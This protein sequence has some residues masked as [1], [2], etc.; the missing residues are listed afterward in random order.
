MSQKTI[1]VVLLICLFIPGASTV[2]STHAD[3]SSDSWV[4]MAPMNEARSG[5]GVAAV[6]GKI[7]A[8]GGS[9]ANGSV[10]SSPPQAIITNER[11]VDGFVGTNEEYDLTTDTWAYKESMPTARIG[12][13]TAVYQNKIYCIGGRTSSGY[14]NANEVYDPKTNMWEIKAPMPIPKAWIT[15]SI[16]GNKIYIVGGGVYDPV[17]NSWSLNE[18]IALSKS[19]SDSWS[20]NESIA[21]SKSVSDSWAL[22][23][24]IAPYDI[25]ASA[26]LDKKIYIVGGF[27]QDRWHN[28]NLIYN[29]ETDS[30]SSGSYPP[31]SVAT[32]VAVAFHE[33]IFVLGYSQSFNFIHIYDPYSDNW[34]LGSSP[35]IS[36]LFNFGI[37]N[38][39]DKLY[40]IGGFT[41]NMITFK[42]SS[43]NQQYTPA[44]IVTPSPTQSPQPENQSGP[45]PVLIIAPII[46]VVII[47]VGLLAYFKKHKS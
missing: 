19:V 13:A 2:D 18:S 23:E 12:F 3:A 32:G 45:S 47:G 43:A 11:F 44:Q 17:R 40:V 15:A 7:Y 35:P 25:F 41:Y 28:K 39:G 8:I 42:P 20:L 14:T 26:S 34:T 10:T 29:I 31:S 1:W 38:I 33:K 24:S 46:S 4:T 21:L 22:N 27:S 30:F 6:D 9:T 37:A 36:Y 5:L 16:V